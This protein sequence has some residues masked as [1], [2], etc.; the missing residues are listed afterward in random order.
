MTE[1]LGLLVQ[2]NGK[3]VEGL[4]PDALVALERPAD[5]GDEDPALVF[6]PQFPRGDEFP[7]SKVLL[8]AV[9]ADA[10][11]AW[12]VVVRQIAT[13]ER[14]IA[15]PHPDLIGLEDGARIA[16]FDFD[17]AQRFRLLICARDHGVAGPEHQEA[18]GLGEDEERDGDPVEADAAAAH[19][20]DLVVPRQDRDCQQGGHQDSERCD[21][22]EDAGTLQHEVREDMAKFG[23]VAHELPDLLDK[24]DDQVHDGQATQA[25]RKHP[26][27]LAQ[28]ICHEK[29]HGVPRM[30]YGCMRR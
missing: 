21:L 28:E 13:H 25:G 24:V 6:V 16:F 15:Q 14:L 18:Q 8:Q 12:R 27:M 9:Q 1:I 23:L 7:D 30:S 11:D 19:R 4:R 5:A 3:T 20:G 17:L 10:V 2:L 22:E 26:E 29:R